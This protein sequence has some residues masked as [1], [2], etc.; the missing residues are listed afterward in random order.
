MSAKKRV[1]KVVYRARAGA[2]LTD[3]GAQI[4]GEFCDRLAKKHRVVTAEVFVEEASSDTRVSRYLEWDNAKA[5]HEHRLSQARHLMGS[6]VVHV[7]RD[8]KQV[9]VRG[10]QFVGS[11]G[12]YVPAGRVFSDADMTKEVVA[13]AK[14]EAVSWFHR[15]QNVRVFDDIAPV[16]DAIESSM[17]AASASDRAA[18]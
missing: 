5:A 7:E 12:G 9:E 6:F 13:R 4:I 3:E 2:R 14:R 17:L 15:Y 10:M 11:E 16:M 1:P 8:E 18:E